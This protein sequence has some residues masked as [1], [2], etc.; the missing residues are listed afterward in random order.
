MNDG[1]SRRLLVDEYANEK[2][3]NDGEVYFNIRK[4][5]G[6]FG[7]KSPYYESQEWARLAAASRS[8]HKKE[9][10][11]QLLRHRKFAAAFDAFQHL[12]AMYDGLR[13]SMVNK[14]IALGCNE[15]GVKSLDIVR[16]WVANF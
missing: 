6:L 14:M 10:M 12:P 15:V 13:L 7:E 16:H 3:P 2:A 1:E 11:E 4:H 5:Q 8:G 9:R